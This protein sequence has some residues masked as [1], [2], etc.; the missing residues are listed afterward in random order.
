MI[1]DCYWKDEWQLEPAVV[2]RCLCTEFYRVSDL[3]RPYDDIQPEKKVKALVEYVCI[4]TPSIMHALYWSISKYYHVVNEAKTVQRVCGNCDF[5]E[6]LCRWFL[7]WK[8]PVGVNWHQADELFKGK[9]PVQHIFFLKKI[10]LWYF[11]F[12][13]FNH[14]PSSELKQNKT[15]QDKLLILKKENLPLEPVHLPLCMWTRRF[16]RN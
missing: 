7:V 13:V 10:K 6:T 11:K 8:Q 5:N 4:W 15:K 16:T 1:F 12:W 3:N 9:P 14:T 2:M